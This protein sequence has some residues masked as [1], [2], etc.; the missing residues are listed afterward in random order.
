MLVRRIKA[1]TICVGVVVALTVAPAAAI[2]NPLGS[3]LLPTLSQAPFP[4]H[5]WAAGDL[6]ERAPVAPAPETSTAKVLTDQ[7]IEL[8]FPEVPYGQAVGDTGAY[9]ITSADDGNYAAG[10][11]PSR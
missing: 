8:T 10:L 3:P 5:K 4:K 1:G 2:P 11:T 7:W 9:V 6:E